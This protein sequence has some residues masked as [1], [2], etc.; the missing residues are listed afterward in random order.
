[1]YKI[2]YK[3]SSRD[4]MLTNQTKSVKR[5]NIDDDD[6]L[7]II[8]CETNSDVQENPKQNEVKKNFR[9]II[10][11]PNSQSNLDN[12]PNRKG[13]L[14]REKTNLSSLLTFNGKANYYG[15]SK[16]SSPV[17]YINYDRYKIQKP[18]MK[19]INKAAE[20]LKDNFKAEQEIN[21]RI[22]TYLEKHRES[23][24]KHRNTYI[25]YFNFLSLS[26]VG[27][28]NL[29]HNPSFKLPIIKDGRL[30]FR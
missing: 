3:S 4:S 28:K 20:I 29:N 19:S 6:N 26:V 9:S 25:E 14:D 17:Q 18:P 16:E 21:L 10:K 30:L 11:N 12:F 27:H 24:K 23:I 13:V 7:S 1:M 15:F 5:I 8:S 22:N 2:N